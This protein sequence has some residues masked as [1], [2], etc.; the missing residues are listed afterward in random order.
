MDACLA[1]IDDRGGVRNGDEDA[2]IV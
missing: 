1:E 2:E